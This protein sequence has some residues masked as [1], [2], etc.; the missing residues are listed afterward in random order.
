VQAVVLSVLGAMNG[1]SLAAISFPHPEIAISALI[2][3]I[4][5][6]WTRGYQRIA[7]MLVPLLL[8]IREDAGLHLA[9]IFGL[10]AIWRWHA[11]RSWRAAW[12]EAMI[13]GAGL[14]GSAA[15]LT[16]QEVWFIVGVDQMHDTYLGTPVLAHVDWAFLGHHIYRLGQNRS[17]IYLPLLITIIVALRRR[18]LLFALGPL[19]GVPWV[20]LALVARSSVAGEL[21]C[22]Y[23][24]PLMIGLCWPMLVAQPALGGDSR[25]ALWLF[26]A[27]A[28][29]SVLLFA[30]SG[31]MHDRRPWQSFGLPDTARIVATEKALDEIL[32]SRQ[33]YGPFIVDDAVG[34]LRPSA[35]RRSELRLYMD[36]TPDEI[37]ALHFMVLVPD[38]WLA[39]E[40]AHIISDA[41]LTWHYHFTGTSLL[42][43]SRT[44]LEDWRTLETAD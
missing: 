24:F 5:A 31:G 1:I 29:L 41:R 3:L 32:S 27:N 22:Y 20:L 30:F 14:L 16:V 37:R 9:T 36:F 34:A 15:I 28:A 42:L 26:A 43:Y 35:F 4:L 7:W 17:Y 44:P 25:A 19:A 40:K 39:K 13:A 18:E 38:A 23:A 33:Q 10:I 8:M 12:P 11:T 2:L 21:M 6:S